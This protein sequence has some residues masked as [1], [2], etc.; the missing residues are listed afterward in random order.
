LDKDALADLVEESLGK[1]YRPADV[2]WMESLPENAVG[3]VDR[4]AVAERMLA[5][6]F[7]S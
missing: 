7:D 5:S 4:N 2:V 3:K 1:L 6:F